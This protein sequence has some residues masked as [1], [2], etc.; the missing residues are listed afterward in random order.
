MYELKA[1]LRDN[2]TIS[3]S[4]RSGITRD[5]PK[6]EGNE[7]VTPRWGDIGK[8]ELELSASPIASDKA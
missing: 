1:L 2:L 7:V 8:F 4:R 6:V 5:F 3:Y